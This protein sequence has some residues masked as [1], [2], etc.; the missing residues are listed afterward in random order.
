[1]HLRVLNVRT[2]GPIYF[3]QISHEFSAPVPDMPTDFNL[4]QPV[5]TATAE[6]VLEVYFRTIAGSQREMRG[7]R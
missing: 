2:G 3:R 4:P 5:A 7:V 1:M 6:E